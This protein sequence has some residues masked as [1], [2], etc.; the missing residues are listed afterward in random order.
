MPSQEE[1]R[2]QR[3]TQGEGYVK[4]EAGIAVMQPWAKESWGHQMLERKDPPLEPWE[5]AG[6]CFRHLDFKLLPPECWGN[7]FPLLYGPPP[8]HTHTQFV[9]CFYGTLGPPYTVHI[10]RGPSQ[11][12]SAPQPALPW[13]VPY[14]VLPDRTSP[15]QASRLPP[16]LSFSRR[17]AAG[18]TR[19]HYA[20]LLK[21]HIAHSVTTPLNPDSPNGPHPLKGAR[22]WTALPSRPEGKW[23]QWSLPRLYSSLRTWQQGPTCSLMVVATGTSKCDGAAHSHLT[24]TSWF[25]RTPLPTLLT[26]VQQTWLSPPKLALTRFMSTIVKTKLLDL[27]SRLSQ[28]ELHVGWGRSGLRP[29]TSRGSLVSGLFMLPTVLPHPSALLFSWVLRFAAT[30]GEARPLLAV[31]WVSA[32]A[33]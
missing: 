15:G 17:K 16:S 7:K 26:I 22:N 21:D 4:T 31:S 28:M 12:A 33:P 8:T 3:D 23:V 19:W 5:E 2:A 25:W 27:G 30:Q 18:H 32:H 9:V 20:V 6:P 14:T 11:T 13:P 29:F 10:P 1:G 24:P